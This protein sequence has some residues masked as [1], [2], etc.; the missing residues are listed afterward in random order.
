[1]L[2]AN[3]NLP[4]LFHMLKEEV[5]AKEGQTTLKEGACPLD[6]L[7]SGA[8]QEAFG[9]ASKELKTAQHV[10]SEDIDRLDASTTALSGRVDTNT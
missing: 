1:M 4:K 7:E 9:Q 10:C 8:V 2:Q 3:K 6:S 5:K